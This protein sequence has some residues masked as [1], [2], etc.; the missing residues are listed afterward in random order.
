MDEERPRLL[1]QRAMLNYHMQASWKRT[2]RARTLWA[3][4]RHLSD[5]DD[6]IKVGGD[7]CKVF[8]MTNIFHKFNTKVRRANLILKK[9]ALA[10][11]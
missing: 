10:S 1:A 4:L 6:H 3:Y 8:G 7:L 11:S 5:Y 9:G 2:M